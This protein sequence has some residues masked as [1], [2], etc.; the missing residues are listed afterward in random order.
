MLKTIVKVFYIMTL[1]LNSGCQHAP[2]MPV[3]PSVDLERFMGTWYVIA[4]IPTLI[5][6]D[7]YNPVE[8]YAQNQ[9][10]SIATTFTFRQGGFQGPQKTYHP[11]GYVVP[12]SGN[13]EWRMQFLWPFKSEYLIAYVSDD[14]AHTIIARRKRDY[15][16]IMS[17]QAEPDATTYQALVAKVKM[18]GYNPEK[19][20]K[21]PQSPAQHQ[22]DNK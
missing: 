20:V 21:F 13:A 14:Y 9:D 12:G 11:T 4:A 15:V 6:R 2:A 7:P 8:R 18:L 1:F 3:E 16:W 22:K 19:L 10:G 17:R 5:E